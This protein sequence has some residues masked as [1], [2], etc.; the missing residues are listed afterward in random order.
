MNADFH[1]SPTRTGAHNLLLHLYYR[2]ADAR[3]VTLALLATIALGSVMAHEVDGAMLTALQTSFTPDNARNVIREWGME[4]IAH[5]RSVFWLDGF[6]PVVQALFLSSTIARLTAKRG[7][8]GK[9]LLGLFS[10]PFLAGASDYAENLF[11]LSLLEHLDT[12]PRGIVL[13]VSIASSVKMVLIAVSVLGIV[14]IL[15]SKMIRRQT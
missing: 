10:T 7:T 11:L 4:N 13:A 5:F 1:Q 3:I 14:I 2:L 8:P 12:L 15:L 6:F 9:V